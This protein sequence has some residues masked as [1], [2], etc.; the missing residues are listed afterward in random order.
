MPNVEFTLT[1]ADERKILEAL[2]RVERENEKLKEQFAKTGKAGKSAFDGVA[3]EMKTFVTSL[4]GPIGVASALMKVTDIMKQAYEIAMKNK[5]IA[6]DT[7]TNI[8]TAR[9]NAAVNLPSDFTGGIQALDAM[10][11]RVAQKSRLPLAQVYSAA[12][13]GLSAKGSANMAQFEEAMT[14]AATVQAGSGGATQAGPLS[15]SILDLVKATGVSSAKANF[16]W[17]RQAG[18]AARMTS[19]EAQLRMVPGLAMGIKTGDT[20]EQAM[21]L[22]AAISQVI[23]D[24]TGEKTETGF[25]NL[26]SELAD[27]K[28]APGYT[29]DPRTGR[30]KE[31]FGILEGS[32]TM[33][34]IASLQKIYAGASPELRRNI[35]EKI[36]GRAGMKG[37]ITAMLENSDLYKTAISSAQSQI[38]APDMSATSQADEFLGNMFSEKYGKVLSAELT[39]KAG[40]EAVFAKRPVDALNYKAIEMYKQRVEAISGHQLTN[41][42]WMNEIGRYLENKNAGEFYAGRV[43]KEFLSQELSTSDREAFTK[44]YDSL[45]ELNQTTRELIKAQQAKPQNPGSQEAD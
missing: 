30:K 19:L 31:A 7:M 28:L 14:L 25:K 9:A 33:E 16:G 11:E 12:G 39:S 36:G 34:R 13:P 41:V 4:I 24:P 27:K 22:Q 10:M 20:A 2:K 40:T 23:V 35:T 43:K 32:N 38:G 45:M 3:G 29:V 8:G 6:A 37:F 1:S 15:G 42:T 44:L 5:Q 21:E 18:S 26:V 17:L